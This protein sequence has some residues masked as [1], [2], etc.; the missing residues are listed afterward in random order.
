MTGAKIQTLIIW[1]QVL[2]TVSNKV[3]FYLLYYAILIKNALKWENT[4]E[5][6]ALNMSILTL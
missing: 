6:K 5:H 4:Y 2:D 1:S 3:V